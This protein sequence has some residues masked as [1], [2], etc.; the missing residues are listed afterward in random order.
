MISGGCTVRGER[1]GSFFPTYSGRAI[2]GGTSRHELI[3]P[4]V[5]GARALM[6]SSLTRAP[7]RSDRSR[8]SPPRRSEPLA[9]RLDQGRE[10]PVIGGVLRVPLHPD[11]EPAVRVL[12]RLDEVVLAR[13]TG[14]GQ[15]PRVGDAL[16]VEGVDE[17]L[18]A[19][20]LA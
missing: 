2:C 20:D 19:Q 11:H 13:P 1:I 15:P 18:L 6:P 8:C 12:H 14:R 10:E 5:N 3:T 7:A 4:G 17:H 9:G 16:V